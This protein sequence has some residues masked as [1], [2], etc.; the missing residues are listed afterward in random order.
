[1]QLDQVH[2]RHREP[3]AVYH[4]ADVAVERDVVEIVLT[5]LGLLGVFLRGIPHRRQRLLAIQGAVVDI[6]LAIQ[7][8]Q[9]ALI[10]NDQR[11][12]L[13]QAQITFQEKSVEA[14]QY[15]GEALTCL[16]ARPSANANSRH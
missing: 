3:G 5:R 11:I 6:D 2:G 13:D 9:S 4:A 15:L 8:Q 1:V 7:R 10:G 14:E 12:D 16:S